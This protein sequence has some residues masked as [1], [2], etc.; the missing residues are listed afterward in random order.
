MNKQ[1]ILGYA[2]EDHTHVVVIPD[3]TWW[4]YFAFDE[5][6]GD[7]GNCCYCKLTDSGEYMDGGWCS[8]S[9]VSYTHLTLPTNREV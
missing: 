2:P 5:N 8:I 6:D 3:F 1:K 4:I 9:A 7:F